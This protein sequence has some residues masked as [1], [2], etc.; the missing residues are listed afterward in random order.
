MRRVTGPLFAE[1]T[2]GVSLSATATDPNG[3][4][5]YYYFRVSTGADGLVECG[6]ELRMGEPIAGHSARGRDPGGANVLLACVHIRLHLGEQYGSQLG[7]IVHGDEYVTP[8]Q[9]SLTTPAT[10]TVLGR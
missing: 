1:S 10:G 8:P 2:G 9:P 7:E 4:P 6:V 5:F 3:D